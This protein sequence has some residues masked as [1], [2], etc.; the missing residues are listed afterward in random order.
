M[1]KIDLPKSLKDNWARF[2]VDTAKKMINIQ[3]FDDYKKFVDHLKGVYI[4]SLAVYEK[5]IINHM[6]LKELAH[7]KT[8]D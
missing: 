3:G 8:I 2:D 1:S 7:Y 5:R 6:I 4:E